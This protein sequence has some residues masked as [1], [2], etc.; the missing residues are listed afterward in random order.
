MAQTFNPAQV[1]AVQEDLVT[2]KRTSTHARPLIKNEVV[3]ICPQRQTEGRAE[4]RGS[5]D[6]NRSISLR[7]SYTSAG[8]TMITIYFIHTISMS[9]I[10]LICI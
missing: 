10:T 9:T 5:N 7:Y 8:C 4:S 1:I 2:I 6:C 3:Y